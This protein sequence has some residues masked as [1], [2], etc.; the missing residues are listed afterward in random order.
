LF[1]FSFESN[2]EVTFLSG[3]EFWLP[4]YEFEV[5]PLVREVPVRIFLKQAELE[6][7]SSLSWINLSDQLVEK[8]GLPKGTLLQIMPTIGTVDDQDPDDQSYTI[9][10]EEGKQ[11]WYDIVYEPGKDR[12]STSHEVVMIDDCDR[13]DTLV[14]PVNANVYQVRDL[15][16]QLLEI[17]DEVQLHVQTANNHEFYWTLESSR[18]ELTFTFSATNLRGNANIYE[19]PSHFRAEQL[20][21]RLG[22][23]IPPLTS[24]KLTPRQ[25]NGPLIEYDGEIPQLSHKLL[26]SHLFSWNL[27][28]TIFTAPEVTGWRLPYDRNAI[29]RFGNSVNCVIPHDP[30]M[31]E[32]PAEPWPRDVMIRIKSSLF[33]Q[34]APSPISAGG[35][36]KSL[37]FTPPGNWQGPPPGQAPPISSA[38]SG[39]ADYS[40]PNSTQTVDGQPEEPPVEGL[41]IFR[42]LTETDDQIHALISWTTLES[43]P[44][45]IGISL[46]VP[47]QVMMDGEEIA[48]EAQLWEE[49]DEEFIIEKEPT[50][51]IYKWLS[52]RLRS[53]STGKILPEI[54]P[55]SVNDV[56]VQTS[57]DGSHGYILF[58]PLD[59]LAES[60][61]KMEVQ[62]VFE[63]DEGLM[64]VGMGEAYTLK[65]L[66]DE[67]WFLTRESWLIFPTLPIKRNEDGSV[68][69]GATEDWTKTSS[70]LQRQKELY[71]PPR[72]VE[73]KGRGTLI[74]NGVSQGKIL[75]YWARIEQQIEVGIF[76]PEESKNVEY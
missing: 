19:G 23:K 75:Q 67:F 47:N 24:C 14:V 9:N 63:Y 30:D 72:I 62:V 74:C 52:G 28:G 2:S 58:A 68:V 3:I 42:G 65:M 43:Y 17:P 26:K 31:A 35:P 29:M 73:D 64:K 57:R 38:A 1:T 27:N 44:L 34:P 69:H 54:M 60:M 33:P 13:T 49:T 4:V 22:V 40:S 53:R 46:P 41:Q 25:R 56:A 8:W 37:T 71:L 21:R 6:V 61:K 15:W 48:H 76:I 59:S 32:F 7:S 10:W 55:E 20:S 50:K 39:L 12:K 11:Y 45:R 16:K 5:V 51:F 18:N 36:P 66:C 70:L